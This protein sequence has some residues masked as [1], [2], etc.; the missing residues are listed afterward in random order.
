MRVVWYRGEESGT[1]GFMCGKHG[2]WGPHS[3]A[4][5]WGGPSEPIIEVLFDDSAGPIP[6]SR[7][8]WEPLRGNS[9]VPP[10]WYCAS[11]PRSISVDMFAFPFPLWNVRPDC[12]G[13]IPEALCPLFL[14]PV[15]FFG[16]CSVASSSSTARPF[17]LSSVGVTGETSP[18]FLRAIS[19][20]TLRGNEM[21]LLVPAELPLLSTCKLAL[22]DPECR[23]CLCS[24]SVNSGYSPPAPAPS[25]GLLRSGCCRGMAITALS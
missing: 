15:A 4:G 17:P 25:L 10:G 23:F 21:R 13:M 20:L 16:N 11:G 12:G 18:L 3:S 2:C 9:D 24:G 22:V 8:V 1:C 14:N 7:E 6:A 19:M 5:F